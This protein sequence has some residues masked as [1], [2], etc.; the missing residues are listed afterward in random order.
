MTGAKDVMSNTVT[1]A[2]DSV[3]HTLTNAVD[4]TRGAVQ[5]GVEMTR[6]AV[7]DGMQMTRAAVSGSVNTVMESRVAQ[8]VSSGMD[9]ALTTSER[10]VDQYLPRTEDELGECPASILWLSGLTAQALGSVIDTI[11]RRW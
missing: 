10:L 7:Q 4:R 11:E 6:A 3:S 1:G 8:M 9:T 2:K 5:D